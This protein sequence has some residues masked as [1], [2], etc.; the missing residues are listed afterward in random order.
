MCICICRHLGS[1]QWWFLQ[2]AASRERSLT[3]TLCGRSFDMQETIRAF[4]CDGSEIEGF[5]A[6]SFLWLHTVNL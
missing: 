6:M 1:V 3:V 5:N 2:V 4:M